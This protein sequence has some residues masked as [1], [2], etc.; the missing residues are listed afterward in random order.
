[1]IA[2]IRRW[3]EA[4]EERGDW[5]VDLPSAVVIATAGPR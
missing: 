5:P 3:R 1:L 4:R 2:L